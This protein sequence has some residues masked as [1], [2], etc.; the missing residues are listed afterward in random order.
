VAI[1]ASAMW[2]AP[3]IVSVFESFRASHFAETAADAPVR[4]PLLG[5]R[6]RSAHHLAPV[7][8][9]SAAARDRLREALHAERIQ[10]S[11]HYPPIHRFS[12]YRDE[13]VSLPRAEDV[14]DRLITLPLHSKLT[15]EDVDLVVDALVRAAAAVG[16]QVE[17]PTSIS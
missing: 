1:V 16:G 4:M 15:D 6:G 12:F 7:L 5:E 13:G 3:T 14:T 10:T 11:V 8:A 2:P 9:P 17:R